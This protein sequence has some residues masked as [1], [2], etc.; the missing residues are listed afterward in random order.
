MSNEANLREALDLA[1]Q[2][3]G[4]RAKEAAFCEG[5]D[6]LNALLAEHKRA[7]AE[8]R[9][10]AEQAERERD[11]WRRRALERDLDV[12][13]LTD[14]AERAEAD[15]AALLGALRPLVEGVLDTRSRG[16]GSSL[17]LARDSEPGPEVLPETPLERLLDVWSADHPGS[18]LL[19]RMRHL[20][21]K[22]EEFAFYANQA[23][24]ALTDAGVSEDGSTV[25]DRVSRLLE[26]MRAL[27]AL[28]QSVRVYLDPDA[29][30]HDLFPVRSAIAAVDATKLTP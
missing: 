30:V 6:A 4:R 8:M 13:Y 19:E 28:A 18:A 1:L 14:R 7:L 21:A 29:K 2:A 5:E 26:R 12:T 27:E 16:D 15:N 10:R 20:E 25:A 17:F 11:E 24:V 9:Q 23:H 3:T 22:V